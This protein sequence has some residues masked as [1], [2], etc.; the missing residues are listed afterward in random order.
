[1][2]LKTPTLEDA[3]DRLSRQLAERHFPEM[4]GALRARSGGILREWRSRSMET[5]P[6][7]DRLTVREFENSIGIVIDALAE[8][9]EC[10][11]EA[12]VRRIV[13]ESPKHGLSRFSQRCS[14]Q[15][16][17]AEER[18]FRSVL[19]VELRDELGRPMTA[20][21]AASL[22]ELLDVIGEYSLL[23]LI[24]KRGEEREGALQRKVSGM[25]RLADLGTLVAGVAHDSVNLLLP[26]R[27]RLDHLKHI[28]L[29]A[30]ARSE[31]EAVDLLVRQFQNA[32]INL[33][34]LSVD[35][36]G[37]SFAGASLD[38]ADW[39]AG[40][41]D[42]N[43]RMLPR[44]VELAVE[45]EPGLPAV[46]IS[47]AALSQAVFNLIR[48]AQQAIT[49]HQERGRVVVRVV[50]GAGGNVTLTIEDDGPGMSAEVIRR[51]A[52]P[53]FTT[54]NSGSGL[55]LALVSALITRSG[56]TVEFYSPAPGRTTGTGVALTLLAAAL[57]A[58]APGAV[59]ELPRRRM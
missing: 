42:F 48:N 18:M 12:G 22:H 9:M 56:G 7:L 35:S 46:Q 5:I 27:M 41:V 57:P 10:R 24:G 28:E 4:A 32:I 54:K 59:N 20:D 53:F 13:T 26:L 39:T 21:E 19:V 49:A 51:A 15:T 2:E 17:L 34:W 16:L 25:H 40:I 47:S 37:P 58:T 8:A 11:D 33:R 36:A 43:R 44:N 52:E 50:R 6:E 31:L 38:L 14:A 30:A 3:V 29:P 1:V 55:G 23:A 45:L